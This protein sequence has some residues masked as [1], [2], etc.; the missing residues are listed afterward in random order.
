M[1]IVAFLVVLGAVFA[2]GLAWVARGICEDSECSSEGLAA[3]IVA[4]VGLVPAL[5]MLVESGRTRGHPW[6]WFLITA[7]VYAVWGLVFAEWVS[8]SP[9]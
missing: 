7:L 4:V 1:V 6:I 2:V 8:G 3:V 5:A 9:P